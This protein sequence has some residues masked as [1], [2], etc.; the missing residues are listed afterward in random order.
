MA[1]LAAALLLGLGT[2]AAQERSG[3]G[4]P[5]HK[6][7]SS[8]GGWWTYLW[9]FGHRAQEKKPPAEP[10]PRRPSVTESARALRGREEAA[11]H[12]RVA[13]C[14]QLRDIAY[15]TQDRELL[16]KAEEL[17]ALAWDT[18]TM[19]TAQLPASGPA[20]S[21]DEEALGR[22][23]GPGAAG[24]DASALSSGGRGARDG[25]GLAERR[26]R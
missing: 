17:E 14:D 26:G 21:P 13:V 7:Q 8:G 3:G 24:L 15:R 22:R 2:A 16:R 11:L 5:D 20:G 19:R 6:P 25:G 12:R 1:T 10:E 4:D 23:L 18:Y 9:P